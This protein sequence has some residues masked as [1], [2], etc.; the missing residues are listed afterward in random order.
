MLREKLRSNGSSALEKKLGNFTV[1]EPNHL[2]I[3]P[4]VEDVEDIDIQYPLLQPFAYANIRWS[5]VENELIYR[6]VEPELNE[7]EEEVYEEITD[8]L[9]E[10]VDVKLSTVKTDDE[11]MDYLEDKIKQI[12]KELD[13]QLSKSEFSK[14]MYYI[15]RNFI[16]LNKI[17]PLMHDPYI[18]DIG[19]DGTGTPLYLIHKKFGSM[20]TNIVYENENDLKEFIVKLAER[21]GR[22]VSYA[23]PL[24]DGSLPDGSRVQAT[25][26]EDV[27]TKGP[28]FSIRKFTEEPFSPTE[29][30][31]LGTVN[32]ELLA[33]IWLC[34][35]NGVSVL[36]CGGVASG[37]TSFLNAIS[38]F[39]PE[40]DKIVSIE[41]TRELNLPHENWIPSQVRSGFGMSSGEEKSYGEVD[42]YDLL[43][44]SFRQNPDYVIVGEV[45]G[46][47][48]YVMFQ[49]MS[50]IPGD[51]EVLVYND[52]HL[53][54]K[55][56]EDIDRSYKVPTVNPD[57]GRVEIRKASKKIKHPPRNE[58]LEIKTKTGRKTRVTGDHSLFTWD[59]GITEVM[60]S[61]L[62]EGKYIVVPA[63]LPSGFLD[64]DY[65]NLL[66]F[67]PDCRVYAPEYVKRAVENLSYRE[68][69]NIC[70]V[71]TITDYYGEHKEGNPSSL[72]VDDFKRLMDE[73]GIDYDLD[74][75]QVKYD[76]KSKKL[77]AKLPLSPEFLR[78]LGYYISE[79]SLNDNKKN[80]K[81]QL[82]SSEG[83]ILEDMKRCIEKVSSTKPSLRTCD[84]GFG[85][86]KELT[87]SNKPLFEFLK[88]YCG[89]GSEEKTIPAFVFGLSKDKIG[90]F[91]TGL[92]N[93]DGSFR[94]SRFVYYT[95]S[96]ELAQDTLQLLLTLGIF[97][98]IRRR[99]REGRD[100]TDYV[101]RFDR[102]EYRKE[103]LEYVEPLES[104]PDISEPGL[105]DSNRKE[106]V[107][108]DEVKE[109][110]KIEL[111]DPE[112]VYDLSVPETESFLGGFGGVMLHN[113][114][115]PAMSTMHAGGVET[116]IKRLESPPI[117]LPPSLVET[118]DL[119][120]NMIHAKGVD[121]SARRAKSVVEVTS[122][123]KDTGNAN[124][125]E[126]FSWV[127]GEDSFKFRKSSYYVLTKIARDK[128]LD[129]E[130]VKK[131]VKTRQALLEWMYENGVMDWKDV[132]KVISEYLRNPE[133]TLED[134]GI[135]EEVHVS[136]PS[137]LKS[138]SLVVE[139]SVE[140]GEPK[141]ETV[142]KLEKEGEREFEDSGNTVD[143]DD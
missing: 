128:G 64:K 126:I 51:E 86:S 113:S 88:R 72:P 102:R 95:V 90:E 55:P 17:E 11:A 30:I 37:K 44:A 96:E 67:L 39:I 107:Y 47:E 79:G 35:E 1:S 14:V 13:I 16:G 75:L 33:Y 4:E 109:I 49:G 71:E 54:R 118:L 106:G 10:L 103:F 99:N 85:S 43:R 112:P 81:I 117:E 57:T 59:D 105:D 87:I 25:Y 77:P 108:L 130:D 124:T 138:S 134:K 12:L 121:E 92:W 132:A 78:L 82:Y 27:S 8:A 58:L 68:A 94:D 127:P 70:D 69:G 22:Y 125:N 56:I 50:S 89:S 73:A 38:L 133:K 119:V 98:R 129:V 122:V 41:D 143:I 34:I 52:S 53:K 91:L 45:R 137:S 139:E 104:D 76:R 3:L 46:E 63:E 36:I 115:H 135:D 5:D 83:E 20:Q 101:I 93:G 136:P 42:M 123:D 74:E 21:C 28:N 65:L 7:E 29:M 114:G 9:V 60:A 141:E 19:C 40:Q 32:A 84:R 110:N 2:L 140:P 15:Y 61:E 142:K 116:V 120:V 23:E 100:N 66:H 48:A 6:V 97:A 131:E 26:S 111:D 31:D 24:L 18:E 80:S 62:E